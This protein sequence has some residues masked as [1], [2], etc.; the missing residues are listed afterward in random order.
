MGYKLFKYCTSTGGYGSGWDDSYG[1]F[2]DYAKN[3]QDATV[4]P[5]CGCGISG[6]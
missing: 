3:G 6:K 5:Q 1:A 2:K 4:C